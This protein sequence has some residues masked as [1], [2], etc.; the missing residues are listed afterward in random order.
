MRLS[1]CHWLACLLCL[2]APAVCAQTYLPLGPGCFWQYAGDVG[3]AFT[4][5]VTGTMDMAGEAVSVLA[6]TG[7]A[8]D[9]GLKQYFS[10]DVG[11]HVLFWG[12]F[13]EPEG[14]GYLYVPP[15]LVVDAPLA[16][17][18]RWSVV[19]EIFSIPD[20]L[21]AGSFVAER[22]V[23][24]EGLETV[25]AGEYFAYA[26]TWEFRSDA[27]RRSASRGCDPT[28]RRLVPGRDFPAAEYWTAGVGIIREATTQTWR[29]TDFDGPTA[30][31]ARGWG[32]I[33]ALY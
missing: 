28:G 11:G 24:G 19:A 4:R 23:L 7:Y 25:P 29:L 30:T 17:G 9:E 21:P 14:W 16:T 18:Q 3:D 13:L 32:D 27:G 1:A 20:N 10:A 2:A 33:K 12:F 26:I 8:P 6:Y 22:V 31:L 15:L 5:T